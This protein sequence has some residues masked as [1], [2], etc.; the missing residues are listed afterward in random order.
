M[1]YA[2]TWMDLAIIILSEVSHNERQT[3]Y[4]ITC[5]QNQKKKKK[6]YRWTYLQK[7]NKLTDFENKLMVTKEDRWRR[8][9]MDWVFGIGIATLRNMHSLANTT[10]Y[11]S[12]GTLFNILWH[13]VWNNLKKKGLYI[14][15]TESSCKAE[16][17]TTL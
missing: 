9:W 17:I 7:R 10:C 16:I 1:P 15:I 4:D 11:I 5:K 2:A 6:G 3:S 12:Q 14:C 13:S 8:E